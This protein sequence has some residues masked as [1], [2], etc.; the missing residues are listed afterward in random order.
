MRSIFIPYINRNYLE[1]PPEA[2]EEA[3]A[4]LVIWPQQAHEAAAREALEPAEGRER[5]RL[6]V[7]R[8]RGRKMKAMDLTMRISRRRLR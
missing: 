3:L 4:D 2:V 5:G 7:T 6:R 8:V 1:C